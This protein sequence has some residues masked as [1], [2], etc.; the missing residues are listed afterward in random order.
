MTISRIA[1]EVYKDSDKKQP[2]TIVSSF[3]DN[4]LHLRVNEKIKTKQ[5]PNLNKKFLHKLN[6]F[7]HKYDDQSDK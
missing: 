3:I 7:Y 1:W 2:E 6:D 4:Y 5:L